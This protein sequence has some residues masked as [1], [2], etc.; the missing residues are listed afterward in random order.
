MEFAMGRAMLKMVLSVLA[1]GLVSRGVTSR[2]AGPAI[3]RTGPPPSAT[4]A[5][6]VDDVTV[7]RLTILDFPAKDLPPQNVDIA[8]RPADRAIQMQAGGTVTLALGVVTDTVCE[9]ARRCLA[10]RS[11][12]IPMPLA[13]TWSITPTEGAR[14][15]PATGIMSVDPT[16][17]HGSV[18]TVRAAVMRRSYVVERPVHIGAL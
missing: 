1:I 12:F 15:D 10:P 6:H 16:T 14:I 5:I 3:D 17:P 11:L 13:P 9:S 18:F 8:L 2:D 7:Q 4:P